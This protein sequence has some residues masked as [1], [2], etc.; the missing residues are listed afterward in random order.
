M[1]IDVRKIWWFMPWNCKIV[2]IK[3]KVLELAI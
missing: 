1:Q 2:K 3:Q